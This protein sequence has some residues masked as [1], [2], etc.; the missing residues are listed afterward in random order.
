MLFPERQPRPDVQTALEEMNAGCLS[1][2]LDLGSPSSSA[3]PRLATPGAKAPATELNLNNA[4][5]DRR[6]ILDEYV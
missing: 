1:E 2:R 3:S 5:P 4:V 6:L